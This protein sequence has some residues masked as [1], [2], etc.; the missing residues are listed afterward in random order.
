MS[1]DGAWD[2]W[3]GGDGGRV[4]RTCN[5]VVGTWCSMGGADSGM[6]GA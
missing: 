3:V 5:N 1:E 4:S 6:N 2:S